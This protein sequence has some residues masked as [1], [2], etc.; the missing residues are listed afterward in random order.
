MDPYQTLGVSKN[1]TQD[2]IK[3]AY[4]DRAKKYHP[5]LNPGSKESELKF[6]ELSGAY[7]KIG[8][9]EE[10]AKFDRGEHEAPPGAGG[11]G[12]RG[13]YYRDAGG[14]RYSES[15]GQGMGEDIFESLF[16]RAKSGGRAAGS[17]KYPG[18]DLLFRMDIDLKDSVLGAE[19]EIA[20][21]TGK[22]LS[23]KIPPGVAEGS[24][25]RFAGQ[26]GPSPNGGPP[27]DA[28]VE[29]RVR[30]DPRFSREGADLI[31]ELP[32]PLIDAVF[33]AEIRVPTLGGEVMLKIPPRS[34][35][36]A[37]LRLA[38]K[39]AYQR[40]SQARGDQII[41]LKILLPEDIDPELEAALR[42]W[43]DRHPK[44]SAA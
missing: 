33:G 10:R 24:R 6:K 11:F 5:D 8:T 28:Y 2:E 21:P 9:V 4:R 13:P 37:R 15:F 30:N 40:S 42:A 31:L 41:V 1:A 16:G 26:G 7:E 39:G 44:G 20:L 29:L 18:E 19:R 43:K 32:V 17:I 34:N 27:G 36:G 35:S 12:Q 3:S 38:G 14:E 22:K 25:L 23:V